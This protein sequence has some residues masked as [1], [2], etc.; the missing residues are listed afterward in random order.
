MFIGAIQS[1]SVRLSPAVYAA[2]IVNVAT[3]GRKS[4]SVAGCVVHHTHKALTLRHSELALMED[5]MMKVFVMLRSDWK[6]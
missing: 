6:P 5:F 1:G 3:A 4:H 2:F